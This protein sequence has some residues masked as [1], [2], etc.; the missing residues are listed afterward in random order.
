VKIKNTLLPACLLTLT[1][2]AVSAV[3]AED[4]PEW[5]HN[6][7]RNMT[8]KAKNIPVDIGPGKFKPKSED[9]DMATT[10]NVKWV[11]KLGSQTYGNPTISKGKV[12]VGTNN[13]VARDKKYKGD[14]AAVYCLSEKTGELIWEFNSPKLG[15]GKVSDWEFLGICSS[16]TVDGNRVYIV[17][18][19]C[20]VI[21]LD[22]E[23]L[24][25]GNEGFKDE[26]KYYANKGKPPVVLNKNTDADIVWIYDMRKDLGVFP[27]NITSSSILVAGDTLFV[28]TSN[29]VDWSHVHIPN[30]RAPVL[31]A[32]NKKTGAYI[33][34]ETSGMSTRVLHG[35]WSSPALGTFAGQEMVIFGGGDGFLYGFDTKPGKD[36]DGEPFLKELWRCD[37]NPAHYRKDKKGK[38]LK[39]A[40]PEGPSE[41]IA[42]PVIYKGKIFVPIGQDP[43]HGEGVGSM[44]CIDPTKRGD[45]TKTGK[46]WTYNKIN[47][48][49][50]TVSVVDDLVYVGD[51]AG[52]VHCLD[53]KTGKAYWTHDTQG[54]IWASTLVTD[55]KVFLGNEDGILTIL[56][57]GKT[58]KLL[59]EIEFDSA[60]YG[61]A[62]VANDVLYI[63]TH[64]H[65][66]AI[67]KK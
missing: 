24:K 30:P 5:G 20:Q 43:E 8:A 13:E 32:V 28:N 26:A 36:E 51:F 38:T 39:Y 46:V 45:I 52:I 48:S 21:C 55:G 25:N 9:V 19:R 57:H 15:T 16:P 10:K 2:I 29:G 56:Q 64:T 4:W 49:I 35:N 11:V 31:I 58:K 7:T 34:E 41:Y 27:H 47:R 3:S 33:A 14:R 66:Y 53:A 54:H 60:I 44:A 59:K 37:G 42:T 61:S 18:N 40:K 23:G 22:T 65:L 67:A 6:K 1:G 50:S 17:T 62:V 63:A 12:Y